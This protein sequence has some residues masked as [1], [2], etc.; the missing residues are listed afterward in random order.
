MAILKPFCVC[1]LCKVPS[2][3]NDLVIFFKGHV[4]FF[5]SLFYYFSFPCHGSQFHFPYSFGR[6][7]ACTRSPLYIYVCVCMEIKIYCERF[8]ISVPFSFY[9]FLV[10]F[11]FVLFLFV[12]DVTQC[13]LEQIRIVLNVNRMPWCVHT[14]TL[15]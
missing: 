7:W 15:F 2:H 9:I 8:W 5:F 1:F 6:T 3:Y 4:A 11:F 12:T 14:I 10:F 13:A